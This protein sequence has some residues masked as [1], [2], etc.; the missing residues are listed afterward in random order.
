[1]SA[2]N[3]IF[4]QEW[5]GEWFVWHGSLSADYYE[6]AS[7]ENG[8]QTEKEASDFA[9]DLHD[10]IS[11]IEGGIIHVDKE[12]QERAL[13]LHIFFLTERLENLRLTGKQHP[14]L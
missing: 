6:P 2:D 10:E 1:L 3:A 5:G 13:L 11:C 14:N 9:H 4:L 12:A 7:F 8:F